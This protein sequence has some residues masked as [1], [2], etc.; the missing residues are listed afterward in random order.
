MH[1]SGVIENIKLKYNRKEPSVRPWNL[2]TFPLCKLWFL[3]KGCLGDGV[4]ALG[5]ENL[6]GIFLFFAASIGLVCVIFIV[7]LFRK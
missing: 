5:L 7:E 3:T 6:L 1:E 4:S 2:E